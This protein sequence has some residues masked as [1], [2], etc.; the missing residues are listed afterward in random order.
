MLTDNC[1]KSV[2]NRQLLRKGYLISPHF[3]DSFERIRKIC[4]EGVAQA[5]VFT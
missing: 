4:T 5:I 3:Y 2:R 1:P